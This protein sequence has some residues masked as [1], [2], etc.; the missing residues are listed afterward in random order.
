LPRAGTSGFIVCDFCAAHNLVTGDI[1]AERERLLARERADY[2]DSAQ[3]AHRV[4]RSHANMLQ[5]SLYGG[6][7]LAFGLWVWLSGPVAHKLASLF[8]A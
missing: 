6:L 1:A 3:R 2:E 7:T 4:I 8:A 5:P